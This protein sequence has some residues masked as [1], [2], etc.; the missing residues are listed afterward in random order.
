MEGTSYGVTLPPTMTRH[1]FTMQLEPGVADEY[2]RRHD[3]IWP[4]LVEA[5]EAAGISDY[6]IFLDELT[7]KLFAVQTL[8][9]GHTAGDLPG[10]PVVRK[11]WDMMADWM[12]TH[13]DGEPVA[14]PLTEMF[15]LD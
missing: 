14:G 5:L 11:W 4:E 2:R 3:A 6:S 9:E 7:G 13:A 15:H 12:E 1:A 10:H 8:A